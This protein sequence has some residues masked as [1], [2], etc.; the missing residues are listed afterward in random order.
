MSSHARK[1]P[2]CP[3]CGTDLAHGPNFCP[4]CGQQNHDVNVTFGHVIEET[5]E[6]VF[7][8]DSKVWRTFKELI[9]RPGLLTVHFVEGRRAS[10]VPPIRL[11][12]FIA[13]VFFFLFGKRADHDVRDAG[14]LVKV[15]TTDKA[16]DSGGLKVFRA[17]DSTAK[18]PARREPQTPAEVVDMLKDSIRQKPGTA[19]ISFDTDSTGELMLT[20]LTNEKLLRQIARA[21]NAF[22]DSLIV[23]RGGKPSFLKRLTY[24]QTARLNTEQEALSHQLVKNLSVGMFLLMPLFGLLLKLFYRR[25]RPLYVQH[26]MFSIHLHS[27]F[28]LFFSVLLVID[29]LLPDTRTIPPAVIAIVTWV[30]WV[31]AL[32]RFSGQSYKRTLWKGSLLFAGYIGILLFFTLSVL[33][34]SLMIF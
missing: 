22:I 2:V 23:A 1:L 30:Y 3:N 14:P 6:G 29:A 15:D 4:T 20:D 24:R 12:V 11:Y 16:A 32:R 27:F 5:L 33:I 13:L 28:F 10:Y 19:K 17:G 21:D 26:L 31:L 18:A 9:F 8:F 34:V 25:Q 7:H